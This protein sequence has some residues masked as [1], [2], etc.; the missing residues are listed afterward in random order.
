MATI[1]ERDFVE[2]DYTARLK[3]DNII[4][5]TTEEKTA[6]DNDIPNSG[7]PFGPVITCV[8]TGS[9]LKGLE[10]NLV[11]K[12]PGK[13][14]TIELSPENAFGKKSAKL[15]KIVNTNIFRKSNIDPVP[16]LQINVDGMPG[17]IRSVTG[18]RTIVDFNH[19]LS[20]K[21][22]IYDVKL[23]RIV[24]DDKEKI[25]AFVSVQFNLK[26]EAFTVTIDA[27]KKATLEFKEGVKLKNFDTAKMAES[28]KELVGI[29]DAV[30]KESEQKAQ[31]KNE[32]GKAELSTQK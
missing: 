14:Y 7:V 30:F 21:N 26:P 13:S 15:L 22:I 6:K 10:D 29:K 16:G 3:D 27:D 12:E 5:D 9:L 18:G 24:S 8:G 32:P 23:I 28:L 20:G 17:T 11:G 31:K 19:P 1:K 2:L 25:K 4:F